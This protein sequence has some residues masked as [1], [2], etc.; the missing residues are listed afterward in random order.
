[1][2]PT[3][4]IGVGNLLMGDEGLGVLAARALRER[5]PAGVRVIEA[6]GVGIHLLGEIEDASRLLLLDCIDADR[7]PGEV[8]RLSGPELPPPSATPLSPHELG[9]PDLLTLA[10]LHGK[11][12]EEVVVLGIQPARIEPGAELSLEV[13]SALPRLVREARDLLSRWD[14]GP[15][16]RT[17]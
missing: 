13:A 9:L 14:A 10:T 17:G 5:A 2:T 16:A 3:T 12:P 4:V 1:M 8:L 11:P 7:P 6:G 15:S